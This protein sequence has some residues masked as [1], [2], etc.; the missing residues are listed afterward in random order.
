M[1]KTV[2]L[3]KVNVYC[4]ALADLVTKLRK[5]RNITFVPKV[6]KNGIGESAEKIRISAQLRA[7]IQLLH[8]KCRKNGLGN[9]LKRSGFQHSSELRFNF[10]HSVLILI[11]SFGK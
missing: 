2:G 8:Q 5:S 4:I 11:F 1:T 7:Q 3:F 6:P 9:Q 10:P